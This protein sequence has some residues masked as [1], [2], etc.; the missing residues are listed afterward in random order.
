MPHVSK[1]K[2]KRK[3]FIKIGTQLADII[4]K[5][6]SSKEINWFLNELLTSTE[7]IMLSKR[8]ALMF[9]LKKGYPFRA[10]QKVLKV[11]PQTV[12]RFWHKTKKPSYRAFVKKISEDKTGKNFWEELEDILLLGMPSRSGVG[13]WKAMER[14]MR[15]SN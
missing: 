11:T 5:A 3:V 15:K 6:N 14:A 9:M 4:N 1:K 10:I 8:L 2:L 7:R 13:R 12:L